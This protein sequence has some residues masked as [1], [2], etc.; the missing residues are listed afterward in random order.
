MKFCKICKSRLIE[1]T[2][3]GDL[4]FDCRQCLESFDSDPIDSLRVEVNYE[5]AESGEKYAVMEEN[6]PADT[7]G[8]KV[9]L[10]CPKCSMPYLTHIYVGSAYISKYVCKCGFNVLSRDYDQ[11][12]RSSS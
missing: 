1:N 3:V 11:S 6:A 5:T 12:S 10:D 2:Q 8:K 7:A 9:A 4:K